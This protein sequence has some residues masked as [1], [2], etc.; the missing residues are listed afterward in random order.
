MLFVLYIF[1]FFY[2]ISYF[3][4]TTFIDALLQVIISIYT[5]CYSCIPKPDDAVRW[6]LEYVSFDNSTVKSSTLPLTSPF[7]EPVNEQS[8]GEKQFF[9]E[10]ENSTST[11]MRLG[12]LQLMT[13]DLR[14]TKKAVEEFVAI[15]QNALQKKAD[16]HLSKLLRKAIEMLKIMQIKLGDLSEENS[17]L[18]DRLKTCEDFHQ[19]P[20]AS[21][22]HTTGSSL[23]VP[24]LED[25][26]QQTYDLS[27]HSRSRSEN[28]ASFVASLNWTT[29]TSGYKADNSLDVGVS[30]SVHIQ[31][32]LNLTEMGD[33]DRWKLSATEGV[34]SGDNLSSDMT[35]S[36]FPENQILYSAGTVQSVDFERVGREE[37]AY[38][39]L[40]SEFHT[41]EGVL[42][43]QL[44]NAN[45]E[46]LFGP[47]EYIGFKEVLQRLGDVIQ[48]KSILCKM[49]SLIDTR[50]AG[51]ILGA[52]LIDFIRNIKE[53][54]IEN[55][56][57][58]VVSPYKTYRTK[59]VNN[60]SPN[61]LDR[62]SA[63]KIVAEL[64]SCSPEDIRESDIALDYLVDLDEFQLRE[65]LESCPEAAWRTLKNF[66]PF[67]KLIRIIEAAEKEINTYSDPSR[68][69]FETFVSSF[70]EAG[71]DEV[72]ENTVKVAFEATGF[73]YSAP[74]D[75]LLA[76]NLLNNLTLGKIQIPKEEGEKYG[77]KTLTQE[78][79][80][81]DELGEWQFYDS[82]DNCLETAMSLKDYDCALEEIQKLW[83]KQKDVRII[84]CEAQLAEKHGFGIGI[85]NILKKIQ[86]EFPEVTIEDWVSFV[87]TSESK[88][89]PRVC[90]S[91]LQ[92]LAYAIF[93]VN[94]ESK[95]SIIQ[96]CLDNFPESAPLHI[97][98]AKHFWKEGDF[99]S[100]RY[101]FESALSIHPQ[102]GDFWCCY[103]ACSR[104]FQSQMN[105]DKI[106]ECAKKANPLEGTLWID[107][108]IKNSNASFE[109][110]VDIVIG[111]NEHIKNYV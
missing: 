54:G 105:T 64:R 83:E 56:F 41:S 74:F 101:W 40:V 69:D 110:I 7:I 24:P 43:H 82:L 26:I 86:R 73:N 76:F 55:R 95:W 2:N 45:I 65:F 21:A 11:E 4:F 48:D 104:A 9:P 51:I 87:K 68:C 89:C 33:I 1:I 77:R 18:N 39:T 6:R 100:A 85:K 27:A 111:I 79:E 57:L 75:F 47:N 63:R 91:L 10:G 52:K 15:A 50:Q 66:H 12:E 35:P 36:S 103:I 62:E 92:H 13:A 96:K 53:H 22:V 107:I 14:E 58:Y 106:Q 59:F 98:A 84:L 42:L 8:N 44:E 88:E 94:G 67:E 17:D 25:M 61:S 16:D 34:H 72:N 46:D 97:E 78:D 108:R 60:H 32:M 37:Y 93:R 23:K 29:P 49:F 30:G 102:N 3:L 81:A 38:E 71:I 28:D 90:E 80:N 20:L 5:Y 31:S 19:E 70:K 99:T 109:E